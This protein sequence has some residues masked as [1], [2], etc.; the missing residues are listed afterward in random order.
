MN[1]DVILDQAKAVDELVRKTCLGAVDW[2][3]TAPRLPFVAAS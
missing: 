2:F 3:S 1:M